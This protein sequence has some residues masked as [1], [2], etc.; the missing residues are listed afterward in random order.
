MDSIKILVTLDKNYL[1]QLQVLLTS[2][3]INNPNETVELYIMHSSIP[4]N[5][6]DIVEQQCNTY[7]Y[8]LTSVTVDSSYFDNAPVTGQYPQ[9]MYYRLLA[10]HLLPK[11]LDRI[12][13]LDPDTL[14]INPLRP[15]WEVDMN[16]CI[17]AAAPHTGKTEL[18]NNVNRARLGTN[19]KYFN[20]GVLLIN[21]YAGKDEIV[22]DDI[23]NYTAKHYRELLLPDQD[24]LNVM[25][26]TKTLELDDYIWNY[27]ARNYKNYMLRSSGEADM[28]WVME[29]T[30]ILHFCGK[31]K[32]WKQGYIH[33]FGVLYKHYAQITRR[34]GWLIE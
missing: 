30:S 34:T 9:E 11:N 21:L 33:R 6:L 4:Q 19:H 18:A 17:F 13:Y 31:S 24:I 23:F 29:H 2:I 3:Y 1:S 26:G 28:N 10:P 27:D 5:L 22:P 25:Y 7:G 32:P 20:S 12:L 16:G 15:L 14:V 8:K